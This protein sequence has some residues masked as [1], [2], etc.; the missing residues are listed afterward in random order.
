M[1]R[2]LSVSEMAEL[3]NISR[4]TLIYY[5]KI[6]LF[7]PEKIDE[8]G[9]RNYSTYQIPFLREI[10]YLKSVGVKLEEIKNHIKN[11]NLNTAISLLDY[12]R[13]YIKREI[14]KL[15]ALHEA[16]EDRLQIYQHVDQSKDE[17]YQPVIE[18]FPKRRI[19]FFPL[20]CPIQKEDLHLAIMQGWSTLA[21]H[22]ILPSAGFGTMITQSSVASGHLLN[23]AGAFV[24]LTMNAPEMDNEIILPAGK[25]VC[26]F[27]YGMPYE[28]SYLQKL[29]EWIADNGY[30]ITGDILDVCILDTTFYNENTDVDFCQLQIPVEKI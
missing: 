23:G 27:K 12:H 21:K 19:L 5:D 30:R 17:L 14:E 22:S 4:Q 11:R 1:E 26:M 8:N 2:Y 20:K 29:V 25:Y 18:D 13:E 3:H 9:Y 6:G 15:N 16:I 28:T 7:S 24:N 10:C